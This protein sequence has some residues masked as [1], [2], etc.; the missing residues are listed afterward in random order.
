MTKQAITPE[1]LHDA[2]KFVAS[3]VLGNMSER[4]DVVLDESLL[5]CTCEGSVEDDAPLHAKTQIRF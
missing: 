4:M 3:N 1:R 2:A 5:A